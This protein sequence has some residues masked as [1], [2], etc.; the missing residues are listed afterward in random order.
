MCD[1]SF[2]FLVVAPLDLGGNIPMTQ[3]VVSLIFRIVTSLYYLNKDKTKINS[4]LS[5]ISLFCFR[6]I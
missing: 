1:Y 5:K 3:S 4:S 6:I 2:L